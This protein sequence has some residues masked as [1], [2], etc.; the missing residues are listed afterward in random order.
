M[1]RAKAT[2]AKPGLLSRASVFNAFL[3]GR[4]LR[5]VRTLKE[6]AVGAVRAIPGAASAVQNLLASVPS[7]PGYSSVRQV[8]KEVDVALMV[9]TAAQRHEIL[10]H[11]Q[12]R[13]TGLYY[14]SDSSPQ[15]SINWLNS[16]YDLIKPMDM[17]LA[18]DQAWLLVG[19]NHETP[20]ED[21]N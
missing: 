2:R 1:S 20:E 8:A 14:Y 4:M 17:S 5:S 11:P 12:K 15:G 10:S 9:E 3:L 21:K 16:S 19:I 7:M 13:E 18:F 6:T